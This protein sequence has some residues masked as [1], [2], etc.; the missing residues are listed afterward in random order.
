MVGDNCGELMGADNLGGGLLAVATV[1][2]GDYGLGQ[3]QEGET[4]HGVTQGCG[5]A[6]ITAVADAL[7]KGYLSQKGNAKL[8]G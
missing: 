5:L 2:N 6:L 8:L 1:D 4:G 7:H 3:I